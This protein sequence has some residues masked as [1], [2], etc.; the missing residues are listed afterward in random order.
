M[1]RLLVALEELMGKRGDGYGSRCPAT[2]TEWEPLIAKANQVLGLPAHVD[3]VHHV[4]F[5]VL[6]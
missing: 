6:Q 3:R 5:P 1:S 4:L 2:N